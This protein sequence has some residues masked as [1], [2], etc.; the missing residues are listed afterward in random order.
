MTTLQTQIAEPET[1]FS[2]LAANPETG[3][4]TWSDLCNRLYEFLQIHHQLGRLAKADS[5]VHNFNSYDQRVVPQ[6]V[7][8]HV[9]ELISTTRL[10]IRGVLNCLLMVTESCL[11]DTEID[12]SLHK[13][14]CIPRLQNTGRVLDT[15][16]RDAGSLQGCHGRGGRWRLGYG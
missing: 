8:V 11:R 12:K 10:A 1:G 4:V 13:S 2:E 15:V 16:L 6:H 5:I 7:K 3:R 14:A 9:K